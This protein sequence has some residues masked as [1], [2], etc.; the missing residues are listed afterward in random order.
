MHRSGEL[1]L[2]CFFCNSKT[3]SHMLPILNLRH[4]KKIES[5]RKRKF[6]CNK[7]LFLQEK[8]SY[9]DILSFKRRILNKKL[10]MCFGKHTSLTLLK[11]FCSFHDISL[12]GYF[13][14]QFLPMLFPDFCNFST[15]KYQV[16]TLHFYIQI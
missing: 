10:S 6:L 15:I 3:L 7:G 4:H 12:S 9:N 2:P 16:F 8:H 1:W 13:S 11:L 5:E 14:L